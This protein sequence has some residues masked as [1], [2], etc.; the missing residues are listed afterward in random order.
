MSGDGDA[1]NLTAEAVADEDSAGDCDDAEIT[2][3]RIVAV[4]NR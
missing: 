1:H 4:R 3:L 2:D